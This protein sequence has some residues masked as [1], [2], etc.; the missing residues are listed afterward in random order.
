LA[1]LALEAIQSHTLNLD[2]LPSGG[3]STDNLKL[4]VE[5]AYRPDAE[6][7]KGKPVNFGCLEDVGC[8][9]ILSDLKSCRSQSGAVPQL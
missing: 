6:V 2:R 4:G 5:V 9:G 8:N 1:A 7:I 3:Y